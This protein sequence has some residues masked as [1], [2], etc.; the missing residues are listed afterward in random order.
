MQ[1]G[2][3]N[4]PFNDIREE[5]EWIGKNGFSFIDLTLEP[6]RSQP[7]D[8]NGDA[9]ISLLAKY[10]LSV[11]GH[12][13]YYLPYAHTIQKVQNT[14]IAVFKEYID[15]ISLIGAASINIHTDKQYPDE[16]KE[17]VL[18]NHITV[19]KKLCD[20]AEKKRVVLMFENTHSGLLSNLSDIETILTSVPK[21]WLHLDIAHAHVAGVKDFRYIL[22]KYK[23]RIRHIHVSD[24]D[25]SF[26]Q[27]KPLGQGNIPWV[28][29]I[30]LIKSYI[31]EIT[32]TLEVFDTDI[33]NQRNQQLASRQ[34]L[35][36][37]W[38]TS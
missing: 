22:E 3:M 37:I 34:K 29:I 18:Q 25:G 38:L 7:K 12:T 21:L 5:I 32:I 27:H 23:T 16:A 30:P 6:S 20:Y 13:C 4:N 10:K 9:I 2:I 36:E 28:R 35:E 17:Q 1:M 8:L 11:I 26:D 15:F 14:A 19:L 33:E 24:N 31:P